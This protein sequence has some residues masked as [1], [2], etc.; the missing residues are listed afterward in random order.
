MSP[1]APPG[2]TSPVTAT[3]AENRLGVPAVLFFVLSAATPFTVVAGVITTGFATTGLT[4]I[5]FAFLLV[6]LLLGLFSVG[7]VS[8]ARHVANAGAF[9]SYIAQGIGRPAGVGAAWVA[10]LAYNAL[11]VGLYGAIGAATQP[12]LYQWFGITPY[13]WVI[14]LVAWAV[15]ATLGVRRIDLNGHVLAVLLLAEVAVIMVYNVGSLAHPA[16]GRYSYEALDPG[17]LLGPGVGAILILAVLG[18]VGFEAAVVFSEESR[19][20]RRTVRTATYLSVAV[21]AVLYALSGWAMTVAA[22]SDR[23]VEVAR[24]QGTEVVFNQAGAYLGNTLVE[25]GHVLFATSLVAAMIAFHNTTARYMFALGRERVLPAGFGRADRV[26][27]A[28]RTASLWQSAVGLTVIVAY[29]VGDGDPLIHLFYWAGTSGG[30][31]VLFLIAAT[32]VAVVAFF[33]RYPHG[34][35]VW[36]RLIAPTVAT[37]ALTVVVVLAVGNVAALLGVSD[38]HP[39]AWAVPT[40][41]LAAA[42]GGTAWG[43]ILKRTRPDVYATIGLGARS[44][45]ASTLYTPGHVSAGREAAR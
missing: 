15:T 34:E 12:L 40:G 22:G 11:Q 6:G 29:A 30:L 45:A 33:G 18:S 2:R 19:D 25:I 5:P 31:G 43:L 36:R 20:P 26:S 10:L 24:V 32:S 37:L 21:I 3:L 23:I 39:I 35:S 8:M 41:Y 28:P 44:V 9:Y 7:Y 17:N 13:W 27:G 1:S 4:G 14:A 16:D 38:A 42:V